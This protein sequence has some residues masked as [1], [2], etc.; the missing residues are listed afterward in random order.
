MDTGKYPRIRRVKG[1]NIYNSFW[2]LS[3][4]IVLNGTVNAVSHLQSEIT[5]LLAGYI[6]KHVLIWIDDLLVH[7]TSPKN[8]L[9]YVE[10]LLQLFRKHGIKLHTY[11]CILFT[12]EKKWCGQEIYKREVRFNSHHLQGLL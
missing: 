11:K 6:S 2:S 12:T 7:R 10:S 9:G 1:V 4:T 8:L 5:A 3:P